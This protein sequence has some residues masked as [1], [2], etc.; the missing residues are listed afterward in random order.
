MDPSGTQWVKPR[1]DDPKTALRSAAQRPPLPRHCPRDGDDAVRAVS[2]DKRRP[3]EPPG[4]PVGAGPRRDRSPAPPWRRMRVAR[5][6]PRSPCAIATKSWDLAS[7]PAIEANALAAATRTPAP[8]P[9]DAGCQAERRSPQPP[10]SA[11]GLTPSAA[12]GLP[13]SRPASPRRRSL[14]PTQRRQAPAGCQARTQRRH[15]A[16]ARPARSELTPRRCA[17]RRFGSR[18]AARWAQPRRRRCER[19]CAALRACRCATPNSQ[20][21]QSRCARGPAAPGRAGPRYRRRWAKNPAMPRA[22][23][24][25]TPTPPRPRRARAAPPRTFLNAP[26]CPA[27]HDRTGLAIP[28]RIGRLH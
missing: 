26:P 19:S 15:A 9:T 2:I 7:V 17:R 24:L 20:P 3:A 13:R 8:P 10:V 28:S 18:Q 4:W 23:R 1:G 11:C 12:A 22:G 25:R 5:A 16:S 27:S 6:T 14:R 21:R